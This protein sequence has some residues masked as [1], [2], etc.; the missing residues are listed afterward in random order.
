MER[1]RSY[2]PS[3]KE[4]AGFLAISL[5]LC[6]CLSV[7]MITNLDVAFCENTSSG[8]S[9]ASTMANSISGIIT[10][11]SSKIYSIFRAILIPILVIIITYNGL[12]LLG[13]GPQSVE[14]AKK[15]M[16][17]AFVGAILIVFAPLIGNEI[18]KWLND[19][20]S[21]SGNL[22]DYNPLD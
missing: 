11:G 19:S 20:S 4:I 18:G 15:S 8:N 22:G 3:K 2:L 10:L 1:I 6:L 17:L 9:A 12:L 14:K 7:F 13:G 21:Y 16:V 5:C